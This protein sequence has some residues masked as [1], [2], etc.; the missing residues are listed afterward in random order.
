MTDEDPDVRLSTHGEP[1][2]GFFD[3]VARL[4]DEC[5][6]RFDDDGM[7]IRAVDPANVAMVELS[8]AADMF[9]AYDYNHQD[10]ELVVGVN[11]N[12]LTDIID[13]ARKGR[14]KSNK[15]DPVRMR[16]EDVH[17][18]GSRMVVEVD[19][20][21]YDLTRERKVSLID[22]DS[23][24]QEPNVPTLDLPYEAEVNPKAFAK[25]VN[26][27][28]DLSD[29]VT[30]VPDVHDDHDGGDFIMGDNDQDERFT[31]KNALRVVDPE[32]AGHGSMFSLDYLTSMAKALKKAKVDDP[33]KVT[34]GED[35]PSKVNFRHDTHG[36]DGTYLL[37][38]R[39]EE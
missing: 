16:F 33:L 20:P 22:P 7:S 10:D 15:G 32:E 31:F 30:T 29:H 13:F 21:N 18:A 17:E 14:G 4:V 1:V 2:R 39:I 11:L 26:A 23:I 5:K 25:V 6:V 19:K 36:Y 24:H 37:A 38:P 8:Y 27:V 3:I 9:P 28:D 12:V 35:Y 34:F